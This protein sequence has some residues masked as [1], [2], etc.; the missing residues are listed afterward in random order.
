MLD[1]DHKLHVL[2]DARSYDN[3]I[4]MFITEGDV[5]EHLHKHEVVLDEIATNASKPALNFVGNQRLIDLQTEISSLGQL[6]ENDT[7]FGFGSKAELISKGKVLLGKKATSQEPYVRASDDENAPLISG[8]AFMANGYAVLCDSLNYK[9]K[10]LDKASVLRESLKLVSRPGDVSVVDDNNV[11][12][13]LPYTEQLQD[14]QVFPRLKTGRIIQLDKQCRGIAVI[15]DEIYI[16]L[17]DDPRQGEFQVLNLN[18][19]IKRKLQTRVSLHSP[20]YI[21]VGKSLFLLENLLQIQ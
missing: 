17:Y 4:K 1:S 20:D 15:C 5:S 19:N 16:T 12:I 7:S 21:T 2:E 10:L 6:K 9:I 3:K 8:S 18:G 11:V 14:I 13:T